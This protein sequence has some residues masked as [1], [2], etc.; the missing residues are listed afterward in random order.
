MCHGNGSH[1]LAKVVHSE[2]DQAL[3]P[4]EMHIIRSRERLLGANA[5]GL[6]PTNH[7][8]GTRP[9][10][11]SC[12]WWPPL[13]SIHYQFVTSGPIANGNPGLERTHTLCG[14]ILWLLTTPKSAHLRSYT[15]RMGCGDEQCQRL[16]HNV[17]HPLNLLLFTRRHDTW[18][19]RCLTLDRWKLLFL[20]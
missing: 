8:T 5:Q 1:A 11:A 13:L 15:K 7:R 14:F 6:S 9:Y 12:E 17:C 19:A 16:W 3:H 4:D 2:V 10:S 18:P 20:L